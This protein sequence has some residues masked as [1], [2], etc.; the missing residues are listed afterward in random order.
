MNGLSLLQALQLVAGVWLIVVALK[1]VRFGWKP[2][3]IELPVAAAAFAL[4]IIVAR[5]AS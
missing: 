5:F 3:R 2:V 1:L 4:A